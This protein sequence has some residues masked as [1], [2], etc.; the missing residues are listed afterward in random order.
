MKTNLFVSLLL[1]SVT[2][3]S[4]SKIQML[5]MS[6]DFDTLQQ[7]DR[8]DHDFYF[9]NTGTEP[10]FISN[11]KTSCGCDVPSWSKEPV[12]PGDSSKINYK[13]DSKRIGPI[14]KSMTI[15]TNDSENPI[16]VV[17]VKGIILPKYEN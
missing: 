1:I 15:N 5:E 9:V 6:Y 8:C 17:K 14:N 2:S 12:M 13:Y 10:L 7:G 3:F 4:Q 16:I 11:V